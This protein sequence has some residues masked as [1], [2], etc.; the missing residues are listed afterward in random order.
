[1]SSSFFVLVL[2]PKQPLLMFGGCSVGGWVGLFLFCF[3]WVCSV[4]STVV[5]VTS[6]EAV[7][8]GFGG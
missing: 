2:L 7:G 4:L 5:V 6:V 3:L 8:F 1:M